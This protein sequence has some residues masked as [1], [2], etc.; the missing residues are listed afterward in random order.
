MTLLTLAM[1]PVLLPRAFT[2]T[3]SALVASPIGH[4]D[5]GTA[6][7]LIHA[8]WIQAGWILF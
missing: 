6:V 8:G 2:G 1:S 4:R 3:F 5:C 7:E